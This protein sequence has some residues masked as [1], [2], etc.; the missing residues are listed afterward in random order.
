MRCENLPTCTRCNGNLRPN[1][2]M[3]DDWDWMSDRS[4]KQSKMYDNF[5]KKIENSSMQ[6]GRLAIIEIGCGTAIPTIRNM[7]ERLYFKDKNS[8][9]IRINPDEE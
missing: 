5:L 9:L 8:I 4:D 1:I 7:C 3:F 2:L 6:G